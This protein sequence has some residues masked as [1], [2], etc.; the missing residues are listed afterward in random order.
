MPGGKQTK[1]VTGGAG[2]YDAFYNLL[3]GVLKI[4]NP[5]PSTLGSKV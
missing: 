1:W 3:L 2:F 5:K 4:R